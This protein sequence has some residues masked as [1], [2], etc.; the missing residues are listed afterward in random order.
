MSANRIFFGT[1]SWNYP[2]WKG[3]VYKRTYKSKAEFS[4]SALEEYS[5]FPAFTCVGVDHAFYR[6][7]PLEQLQGYVKQ[8]PDT[9]RWLCKVWERITIPKYPTHPRYGENRGKVNPD[10]LNAELFSQEVLASYAAD[11]SVQKRTGPF[12]F[13]FPTINQK[14]LKREEFFE[15]LAAFLQH[16][17]RE[18][19]YAVEIRN[20]E[21]L[22]TEYFKLLNEFEH[23][24]HCFNHWY[25]MP[26]LIDQM[27]CAAEAGGIRAPFYVARA[28]TP[29]GVKY[30]EAVKLF[31]PYDT[32]KQENQTM[33]ADLARLVHRALETQRSAYVLV[34]NR[35]EG[36]APLTIMAVQASLAEGK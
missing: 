16:I 6:P 11:M 10:F 4:R 7:P 2:G 8:T 1:S 13:Q 19:Q 21:Y 5:H 35:A 20:R 3:L 12:I 29:L 33:R 15:R 32:I 17:P 24:T 30:E 23:V 34:N 27:R 26:A 36:C 25:I 28:L 22:S 18:F 9:F 31:S 14:V